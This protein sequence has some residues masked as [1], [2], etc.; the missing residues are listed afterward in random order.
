[1]NCGSDIEAEDGSDNDV[2]STMGTQEQERVRVVPAQETV[3]QPLV[4]LA[5]KPPSD[6]SPKV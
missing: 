1:M 3:V 4:P 5:H 2:P 6:E